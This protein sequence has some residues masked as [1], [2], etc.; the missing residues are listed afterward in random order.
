MTRP[1]SLAFKR[2]MVDRLTG[3]DALNPSQLSRETGIRQQSVSRWLQETRSLP[4][5]AADKRIERKW[6]VEQKARIVADGS[7]LVGQQLTAF[8]ELEGVQLAHFERWRLALAEDGG[9]SLSSSKRIRKLEREFARKEGALAEAATLLVKKNDRESL[10]RRGRRH[11]R[12][13]REVILGAIA[14]A[15]SAG[16]RLAQACR[17]VGISALTVERW[18]AKPGC[19]DRRNGSLRRPRNALSPAELE[20]LLR[21][22]T[23]PQYAH[24]SPRQSCP[25]WPMNAS[26]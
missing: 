14:Q 26:I 20:Q 8:L 9:D 13:D 15:Q 21:V 4:L 16:P 23:S 22:L 11:R 1:F 10:S 17:I 2:K 6:T 19:E 18:R 25:S 12:V 24:L 3:K 7:K 5:V